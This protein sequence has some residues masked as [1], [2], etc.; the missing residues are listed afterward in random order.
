MKNI[1]WKGIAVT[2]GIVI[3]TVIF[4][5]PLVRPLVSKIPLVGKYA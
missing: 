2:V 1:D 5:V 3:V 4:I